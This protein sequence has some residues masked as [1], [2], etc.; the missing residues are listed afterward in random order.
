MGHLQD[1]P[2]G[3]DD[4]TRNNFQVA[5]DFYQPILQLHKE[6]GTL[7]SATAMVIANLCVSYIMDEKNHEA[8]ELMKQVE[9][10]EERNQ[11]Q[12]PNKQ[13]F[14]CL[15]MDTHVTKQCQV[16]ASC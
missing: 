11:E 15:L 2:A 8:E 1:T 10:E 14:G 3:K 16:P 4:A 6:Q 13:V 12:N 5:V 7:L 9:I